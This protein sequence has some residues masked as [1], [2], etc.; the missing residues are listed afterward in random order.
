M[1]VSRRLP[2]G[3]VN[4]KEPNQQVIN[5][6]SA[7]AKSSFGYNLLIDAFENAIISPKKSFVMNC[8]YRVPLLHGLLDQD[9]INKLKMSPTYNEE[10]FAREYKN[11]YSLNIENCWKPLKVA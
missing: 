3:T 10:S 11:M 1:N 2:D 5:M 4:P 8:D 7:G 9:Y 6:T